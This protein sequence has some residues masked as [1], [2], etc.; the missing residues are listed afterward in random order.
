MSARDEAL[1]QIAA[2]AEQHGLTHQDVRRALEARQT[3]VQRPRHS[4]IGRL[5]ATIGGTLVIA[6][7]G[8]F[9]STIW[10]DLS[11]LEATAD[12]VQ[13]LVGKSSQFIEG[14]T[15][16]KSKPV[17]LLLKNARWILNANAA[18]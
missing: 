11:A 13:R 5:F 12:P 14:M 16:N 18:K 8:V 1:A 4:A 17:C 6:G 7:L 9:L 3:V 2:L 10:D 15:F